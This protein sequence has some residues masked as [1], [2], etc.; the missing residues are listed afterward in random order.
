MMKRL[1]I[2]R[3]VLRDTHAIRIW[4]GFV[5]Y[6]MITALIIWY[7]EP[8]IETYRDACWYCYAVI[9]TVGFGDILVYS[10][11]ARVLSIIL[12]IY[13]VLVIAIITG[14]IV[15]FYTQ[16]MSIRQKDSFSAFMEKLERLPELSKEELA[17]MSKQ[18][19]EFKSR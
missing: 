14:I 16:M 2:L 10:T 19:K 18:V 6:F 9:S 12:S 3:Q 7:V 4:V 13:A 8:H 15:N 11:V 1:R 5:V 17:E